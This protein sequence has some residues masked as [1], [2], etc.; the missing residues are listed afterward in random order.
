MNQ[1]RAK[2]TEDDN[3]VIYYAG[4]GELD[5]ANMS[6]QWLPIDAEPDNTA[7]WISNGA[8]TELVNA[9][10]AK[11]V[12]VVA[13]SC[14]SGIMTRSALAAT[15]PGQ[16]VSARAT[17]LEKM[18]KKRSRTVLTSG[19]VAPV[20]DE[21][22]GD[23]SVFARAFL[24]ALTENDDVLEGQRLFRSVSATVASAADRYNIDQVPE[25]APIRHAGHE[26]GDF[27]LVPRL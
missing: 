15:D 10:S 17:W 9:I 16:S 13:D 8:L 23:H 21:G 1:L 18:L 20:L 2:L 26:S 11:R 7:N 4:H 3:L 24:Q 6:G 22:G 14:Y 12:L 25:Y 27:F 5:K 19:G